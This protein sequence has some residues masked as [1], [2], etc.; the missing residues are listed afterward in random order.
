[1][2]NHAKSPYCIGIAGPSCSG[3]TSIAHRLAALLPGRSTIFGL[4]SY[5]ADLSHL[6][7][8]ERKKFNFDD[9][10]ALQDALLAEHLLALSRGEVIRRP[11]YDFPT[12]TRLQDRFDEIRAG[13]F[14]I[15]E[16]LFTFHWP[17]VRGIFDFRA[18]ISTADPVCLER[19]KVRDIAERGRTMQFVLEQ[20]DNTVR[21]GSENFILPTS[22]FAHLV[23]S[24]EQ[25]IE[26]SAH[27]LYQAVSTHQAQKNSA[28]DKA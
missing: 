19:R 28:P 20:Y 11:V 3:K 18:F 14:L 4:D 1:M 26:A 21:P 8:A 10:G 5:Y 17:E 12:H 6:P 9:P 7:F 22:R 25:P 2:N 13:D 16:G 27:Q 15:V 23:I 24:G